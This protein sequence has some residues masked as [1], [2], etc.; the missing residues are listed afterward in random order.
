MRG[1]AC[2]NI[3]AQRHRI[4]NEQRASP[5]PL[6]GAQED[7]CFGFCYFPA[8]LWICA[9]AT[10]AAVPRA[11]DDGCILYAMLNVADGDACDE[12]LM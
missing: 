8:C 7:D 11:V 1:R 5:S 2:H 9:R 10:C 6:F 12:C 4:R 3:Y